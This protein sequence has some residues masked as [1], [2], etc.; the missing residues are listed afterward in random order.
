MGV[1]NISQKE[2]IMPKSLI[3]RYTTGNFSDLPTFSP[4]A[5]FFLGGPARQRELLALTKAQIALQ[6]DASTALHN[7]VSDM[8][9]V[10]RR[11]LEDQTAILS[12]VIRD[13]ADRVVSAID[14]L[15]D[16]LSAEIAE[17]R[18]QLVQLRATNE[19]ILQVLRR[20]RSTQAQELLGQGIRNLVND[21]L[22]Q[23]EDR[24]IRALDLDNTD[25]Q[26]LMNL[27]A[28]EL[29]KGDARRAEAYLQDAL[30]LP[31][32]LDNSARAE[33]LWSLARIRYAE[34]DYRSAATLAKASLDMASR[35]RRVLQCGIYMV[36]A[37]DVSQGFSMIEDAIRNDP[38]LFGIVAISPDLASRGDRVSSLLESLAQESIAHLRIE[39]E[40]LLLDLSVL[41]A[42]PHIRAEAFQEFDQQVTKL[43]R[44]LG[45]PAYSRL[46]EALT[47]AVDLREVLPRFK[48]L[49]LAEQEFISANEQHQRAMYQLQAAE[50]ALARSPYKVDHMGEHIASF[51]CFSSVASVFVAAFVGQLLNN[52]SLT[53]NLMS[54][55]FMFSPFVVAAWV[56]ARQS[57]RTK[58]E[59]QVSQARGH[60]SAAD[61]TLSAATT[62]LERR[63][64]AA[65]IPG[66]P[67]STSLTEPKRL[68]R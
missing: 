23:A 12:H 8:A 31:A 9:M 13:G 53:A 21:K 17:I 45:Q 36:L 44:I 6:Q 52:E 67:A 59:E 55:G 40:Q 60:K 42:L 65:I 18:W 66:S 16:R 62:N 63:R 68:S 24:F 15:G 2:P 14:E 32:D 48:Q 33:T 39:H 61:A 4:E 41:R 19:Q 3:Q 43:S 30:T 25:Y 20:P 46:R 26:V 11:E 56:F 22:E 47:Y 35:P 54:C 10:V 27:S 57:Y 49:S 5:D 38:A 58:R 34:T 37:N 7:A 29:R 51:G 1:L 28:I 50:A 64:R